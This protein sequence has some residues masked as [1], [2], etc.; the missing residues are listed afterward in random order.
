[1]ERDL[2]EAFDHAGGYCL[3]AFGG[4]LRP[5]PISALLLE[6]AFTAS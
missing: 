1:M 2:Y 3:A 4:S 5:R 6:V